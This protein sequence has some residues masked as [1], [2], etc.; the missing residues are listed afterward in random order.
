MAKRGGK[1]VKI[2]LFD[3]DGTL[4]STGGAGQKAFEATFAALFQVS[5]PHG[6]SFSGRTDR[7]IVGDLFRL[8]GIENGALNW[9]R[10]VG[11]YLARLKEFLGT[12]QGRVLPGVATLVN[13]LSCKVKE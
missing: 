7:A 9:E 12:V 5:G 3:I 2:C 8:Y 13:L 1:S 4:L 6:V 10:F 11:G